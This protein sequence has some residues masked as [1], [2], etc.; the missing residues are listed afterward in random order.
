MVPTDWD[1]V[2]VPAS[3]SEGGLVKGPPGVEA[4]GVG[5]GWLADGELVGVVLD[6]PA[7]V[8]GADVGE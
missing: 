1:G 8:V 6:E 2:F 3:C 7:G 4:P 5:F